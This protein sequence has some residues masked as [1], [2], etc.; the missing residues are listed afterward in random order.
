M[1]GD[2]KYLKL[3]RLPVTPRSQGVIWLGSQ[4]GV[5]SEASQPILGCVKEGEIVRGPD[6]SKRLFLVPSCGWGEQRAAPLLFQNQSCQAHRL[7]SKN[8]HLAERTHHIFQS[9]ERVVQ[10]QKMWRGLLE[11][12]PLHCQLRPEL[13]IQQDKLVL[14]VS[15]LHPSSH[16]LGF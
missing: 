12:P 9:H 2:G 13:S 6:Q 15:Y 8:L 3:A 11:T 10:R 16:I 4:P 5:E 1:Q 7:L 14:L